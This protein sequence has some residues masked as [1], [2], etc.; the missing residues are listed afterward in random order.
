M[1]IALG[2]VQFGMPYGAF[3]RS[4]RVSEAEAAA[5]LDLAAASGIDTLDTAR[6]YGESEE[7]LGRLGAASRFRIVTKS[8]GLA[9]REVRASL[10]ASLAALRTN[11]VH[12]LLMHD[13]AALLGPDAG[14]VWKALETAKAE[15]L[16]DKIGVSVY[17][18]DKAALLKQR[19]PIDIIQAPYSA[20]DQR[21]RKA[22][23]LDELAHE[24]VEI[25]TRSI[26]LQGF[27]LCQPAT[28]P[29]HFRRHRPL[30]ERFGQRAAAF[31]L[32]PLEFALS[33][34]LRE[35]N[36]DRVVVG[37]LS[38]VHLEQI[39]AAASGPAPVLDPFEFASEDLDL[40]NPTR[41]AS[42]V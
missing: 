12:A 16:A 4:G 8:G 10:E 1:K 27:A 35:P 24:G 32:S 28:L 18:P 22:G 20:F 26:F 40:I 39:L 17:S 7:V 21:M 34:G 31:N 41:W 19:F 3:D 13:A 30:L 29:D 14:A 5:C 42:A 15:G 36:I 6:A 11:K 2:T 38:R 9:S 37:V 23:T 33:F 25:H